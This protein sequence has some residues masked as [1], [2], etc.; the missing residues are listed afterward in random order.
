MMRS[1]QGLKSPNACSDYATYRDAQ[2]ESLYRGGAIP[3]SDVA[4]KR[5]GVIQRRVA[6]VSKESG[7]VLT[8]ADAAVVKGAPNAHVYYQQ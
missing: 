2:Q 8:R 5:N 6:L 3:C 4:E 7:N 1:G